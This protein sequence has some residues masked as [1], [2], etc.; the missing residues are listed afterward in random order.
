MKYYILIDN[1]TAGPY[2]LE[3][4]K[5]LY[6][7]GSI[8]GTS[9]YV[10]P[11]S[12]DWIPVS[13][14]VPLF[15]VPLMPVATTPIPS[16][17]QPSIIINNNNNGHNAGGNASGLPRNGTSRLVYQLLAVFLGVLGVHNFYAGSNGRGIIQLLLT[18]LSGGVLGVISWVWAVI[19][20]FVIKN[21][22]NDVPMN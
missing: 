20:I 10:T 17:S 5:A 18:V 16:Q 8:D 3:Q 15:D 12:K 13:M 1:K 14:L 21:D 11:D 2:T 7:A 9:L 19:E 6:N 22:A 4:V